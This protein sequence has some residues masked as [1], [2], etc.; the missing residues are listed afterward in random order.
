MDQKDIVKQSDEDIWEDQKRE[1]EFNCCMYALTIFRF[2]TDNVK[3]LSPSIVHRILEKHDAALALVYIIEE[4]PFKRKD[5]SGFKKF[6]GN[7]W[8]K[9][10]YDD[11]LK[12]TQYEAQ[13]WLALNN[14]LVD[15]ET[16]NKYEYTS[17]RRETL[18]RVSFC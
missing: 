14:L 17:H 9:V 12:V 11:Y 3:E 18:L 6:T 13:V 4:S 5:K 15:P 2:I 1:I 8:E 10:S 16:R 7:K